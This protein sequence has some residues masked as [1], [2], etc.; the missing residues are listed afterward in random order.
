M[1]T[2]DLDARGKTPLYQYLYQHIR[3]DIE[4][5]R[6]AAH[7]QLPSKRALAAHLHTSV[8][9]VQ[10]AYQQLLIEG[11]LYSK[12]K[13]GYFAEDLHRRP[14][15]QSGADVPYSIGSTE[16]AY[17]ADFSSNKVQTSL[18]P[19]TALRKLVRE[20]MS[21]DDPAL[22]NTIPYNGA[23]VL[24]RSIADY[25]QRFKGMQVS[26]EQIV[27]GCGTEY[28]Y[29][30]LMQ[31]FP[32]ETVLGLED[33]GNHKFAQIASLYGIDCRY[34]PI[35]REGVKLEALAESDVSLL[36]LS[37]A[38]SFPIGSV[39][40]IRKRLDVL[41]W[42]YERDD[43]Y[44]VEDDFDSEIN[45]YGSM[46]LPVFHHDYQ[47]RTI[48]LNSF[49][50]TLLPSLRVAYMVLPVRLLRAYRKTMTFYSCTVS[51]FIQYV[52]ARLLSDGYFERHLNHM[53]TFFRNERKE[54]L[55]QLH[56]LGFDECAS[57][58]VP[59][60]GTHLM[61]ALKDT[62]VS[63]ERM[64]A[65][66]RELD[67]RFAFLSDYAAGPDDGMRRHIIVNYASVPP[68]RIREALLRL[69]LSVTQPKVTP[70]P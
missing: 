65:N 18:F 57:V 36:H 9:T 61:L 26:P 55:A 31:L 44:L 6:I 33:P 45:S 23:A 16:H 68:E 39:M 5:G 54:V 20:A 32:N 8:I 42:L 10:N 14:R 7:E 13:V 11:Y 48:Y 12:E 63:Q 25:L 56:Q 60:A 4:S 19:T 22:Y 58:V 38:N 64:K 17:F 66:A 40:P 69:K 46:T 47:G 70:L 21:L 15:A 41:A 53:N 1:L 35:D 2:Y 3:D 49:S 28:L 51:G 52:Y 62:G 59:P 50:K 24:R 34:V 37:P 67:I 27:I 30:R 29:S 43:R